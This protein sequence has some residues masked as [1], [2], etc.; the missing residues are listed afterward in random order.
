MTFAEQIHSIY[1]RHGPTQIHPLIGD[2]FTTPQPNDLRVMAVGIN[3]YVSADGQ[4]KESPSWFAGWFRNQSFRYQRGAWRDLQGLAAGLTSPSSRLASKVFRGMDGLYLTNAVKVY[5]PEETGKRADQLSSEDFERHLAQWHDELDVM[6]EHE[7]LP[8]VIAII[9]A[10]FW[11]YACE[12]FRGD[13][14]KMMKVKSYEAARRACS[15]FASR[16]MLE[17]SRGEHEVLL[18][19]LRHPAAR[20]AKGSPKWLYEQEEFS[21]LVN[22]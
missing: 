2:A 19:R 4:G 22:D 12:S 18:V 14:F 6:S 5:V 9:G 7:V 11:A 20:S 13:A 10:P 17:V 16:I 15:H 3:S 21:R 8:H 1:D